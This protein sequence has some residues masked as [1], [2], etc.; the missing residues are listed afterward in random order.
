MFQYFWW[1][2]SD[3]W[4]QQLIL[5]FASNCWSW[6]VFAKEKTI[7]Y[8]FLL[9]LFQEGVR[10]YPYRLGA[11]NSKYILKP[12]F[13]TLIAYNFFKMKYWIMFDR[14]FD[15]YIKFWAGINSPNIFQ[16]Q[17]Y[18]S[19]PLPKVILLNFTLRIDMDVS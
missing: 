10:E 11:A 13:L 19:E 4:S 7:V 8:G 14:T 2:N 5:L 3:S 1:P 18:N 17:F 9:S 16:N 12:W 6:S 15:V